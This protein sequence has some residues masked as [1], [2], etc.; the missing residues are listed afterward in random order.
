[1]ISLARRTIIH[2][3][4]LSL[5]QAE[6]PEGKAGEREGKGKRKRKGKGKGKGEKVRQQK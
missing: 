5:P 1:L 2:H 6:G 4:E 3:E